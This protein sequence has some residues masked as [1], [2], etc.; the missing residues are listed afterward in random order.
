MAEA[1]HTRFQRF[2]LPGFAFKAVVIGGGYATGRELAEF[3]LP[4]GPM[5]GVLA[6]LL[7]MVVW[8][9]VCALTFSFAYVTR[10]F[11]Y[12]GFF[13]NL[14]G[15]FWIGFEIAYLLFIVLILAVFGAAAGAIGAALFGLPDFVGALALVVV[16]AAFTAYGNA[17]VE[18]LFKWVTIFLYGVYAVFAVLALSKF[19]DHALANIAASAPRAGWPLNG[20][21]YAGYNVIGA[22]IILP[23]VRHFTS[24][25]DAVV[26][27]LLS[28][29]LAIWPAL[30]FFICMVAFY[31]QIG[32]ETLPSDF[33]LRQLDVPVFHVLFQLMI[34]S[35][36]VE[37][38]AGGVNAF[39]ERVAGAYRARTSKELS[40]R[41]R[42]GIAAVLLVGSVFL[43]EKIG[44][45]DLIAQ[46]YRALALAV[47]VIFVAPL[48][49]LGVWRLARTR[50]AASQN[51]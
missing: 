12:R 44:L 11:D 47:I 22:V 37:S 42:L 41:T 45:V 49:T 38:G 27:G 4:G 21:T 20:L 26:A 23:V 18:R 17:A 3:F 24:A 30:V 40:H 5:G 7:T 43:A 51:A 8:S 19:G 39:N 34:F 13:Q 16:I 15:P 25:K 46:G 32:G 36:L 35:A 14:L 9:V 2:L 50:G 29:P 10:S 33:L 31:P 28:G 1:Q 6:I 48:L